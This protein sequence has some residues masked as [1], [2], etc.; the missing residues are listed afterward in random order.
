MVR[1][2]V[3]VLVEPEIKEQIEKQKD[4]ETESSFVRRILV[5]WYNK[6]PGVKQ[7]KE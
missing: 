5:R 6:I 1:E 4:H 7:I 3:T 2:R